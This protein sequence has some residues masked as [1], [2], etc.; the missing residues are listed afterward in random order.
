MK[1]LDLGLAKLLRPKADPDLT[2][3][4]TEKRGGCWLQRSVRRI[5]IQRYIRPFS[6][7]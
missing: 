3:S 1:I 6:S 2:R 5:A 7:R 4:A